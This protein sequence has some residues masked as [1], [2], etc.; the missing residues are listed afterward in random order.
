MTVSYSPTKHLITDSQ[1]VSVVSVV[2]FLL[3]L[4]LTAK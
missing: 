2:E 4:E 1:V 3:V